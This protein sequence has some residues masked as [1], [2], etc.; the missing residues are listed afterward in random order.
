VRLHSGDVKTIDL[1]ENPKR[2]F[3]QIKNG[4]SRRS[5]T[6]ATFL[7]WHWVAEWIAFSM[8]DSCLLD[9]RHSYSFGQL[10]CM[11][12]QPEPRVTSAERMYGGVFIT[13]DDGKCAFYSASLLHVTLPQAEEFKEKYQEK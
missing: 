11:K 4:W 5:P 8:Y 3:D 1:T 10:S 2:R 13:F 9:D 7:R 6:V 12:S